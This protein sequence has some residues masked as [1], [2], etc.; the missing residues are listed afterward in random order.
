MLQIKYIAVALLLA[1]ASSALHDD[2][3]CEGLEPWE[4]ALE[5]WATADRGNQTRHGEFLYPLNK[6]IKN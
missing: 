2:D 5:D 3:T 6:P 1:S 4:A